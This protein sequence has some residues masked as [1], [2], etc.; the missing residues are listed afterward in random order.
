MKLN[1]KHTMY[2]SFTGYIVQAIINNF[3][4]LLFLTFQSSYNIPISKIT[5]LVTFNFGFQL[6]IDF[7]SAGFIDKIGYR[8]SVVIAHICSASGLIS[9]TVLPELFNDPFIG[10][11]LSVMIYAVGGGL[12]EVLISPIVEACPTD[13]K[14]TAMSLLHSFY[15]WGHV[16]VVLL[17][18]VFFAV[19]G[20]SNWKVLAIIWS[21]VP[22][23]NTFFFMK[24]PIA[25]LVEE[26]ENGLTIKELLSQK[27]FWIM[28]ILMI[29]AGAS[30]Q[31]ISQWASTFAEKGLGVSKSIGDLAGPMLFAVMMGL[32]RIVY[33]K[34]GEKI[35]LEKSMIY[36][37]VLCFLSY[38]IISL[39]PWPILSLIGCSLCGLSVGILWPGTFSIS[40]SKIKGGSTA[41]F[42][43]LALAG[44]VG[45]SIGPT[46]VGRVS[47]IFNDNIKIGIISASIFPILLIVGIFINKFIQK[48]NTSIIEDI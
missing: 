15:C 41:M 31:S 11:I 24:V 37:G 3:I 9:L 18:T 43:F 35:D 21:I 12:I 16:G 14:E 33:S 17:S 40:S 38:L 5:F 22:L 26:D 20:I 32:S 48:P 45:C 34:F 23:A 19:F 8:T 1:Y 10:L 30:E 13:N 42:A 36:S 2:A 29:C 39:S 7:L 4:P 25:N 46:V 47:S 27:I 28:V 6:V 44:D